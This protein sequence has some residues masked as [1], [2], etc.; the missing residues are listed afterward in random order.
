MEIAQAII[1]SSGLFYLVDLKSSKFGV[2]FSFAYY[3]DGPDLSIR[4]LNMESNL[5]KV[6]VHHIIK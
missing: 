4:F 1:Q 3:F 5:T 6:C 2:L